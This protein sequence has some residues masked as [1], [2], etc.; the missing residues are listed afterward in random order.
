MSKAAELAKMGEVL[1]NSQ[2]GGRRNMIING[3]MNVSQRQG[4]SSLNVVSGGTAHAYVLDRWYVSASAGGATIAVQQV[5]D[6]PAG[7]TYSSKFTTGVVDDNGADSFNV[8]QQRIEGYNGSH[9]EFGTSNAKTVTISFWVKSSLTGT[10]GASLV[11]G[12]YDKMYV[13]QYTIN[14]A[15]TWEKKTVTIAGPTSGGTYYENNSRYCVLYFDLGS[16]S[17]AEASAANDWSATG[18]WSYGHRIS[19]NV[20]LSRNVSATWQITGV[21]MEVGQATT[22]EHRSYGE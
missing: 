17:N 6:G 14:S 19:G 20:K 21:Q 4:S 8:V 3:A 9:L 7:F 10:F 15:D 22:F 1:T 16:G 18:T 11:A 13:F 5:E 12:N 2:V